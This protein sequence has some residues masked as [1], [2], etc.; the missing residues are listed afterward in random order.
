MKLSPEDNA[1]YQEYRRKVLGI[2]ER[3]YPVYK[4]KKFNNNNKKKK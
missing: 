4:K 1:W 3:N 2:V